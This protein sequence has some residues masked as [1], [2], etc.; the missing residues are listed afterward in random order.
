MP[1]FD[2]D[3]FER[4]IALSIAIVIVI[5]AVIASLENG[6]TNQADIAERTA[7]QLAIEAMGMRAQSEIVASYEL[8]DALRRWDTLDASGI[9]AEIAGEDILADALY[10]A[11]DEVAN[12]SAFLRDYED[13]NESAY[14]ADNFI[15]DI[16]YNSEQFT[17]LSNIGDQW[18]QK[19]QNYIAQLTIFAVTL[20][21]LGLSTTIRGF[22][23]WI[24]VVIGGGLFFVTSGWTILTYQTPVTG[25]P[26]AAIQAYAEAEARAEA[27]NKVAALDL[28]TQAIA[29]APDYANA[30]VGRGYAQDDW[31]DQIA[32]HERAIELGIDS[33]QVLNDLGFAYFSL[34]AF[35]TARELAQQRIARD[36]RL[37]LDHF[38]LGLIELVEGNRDLGVSAY[39]DGVAFIADLVAVANQQGEELPTTITDQLET[40]AIDLRYYLECA[41]FEVCDDN[42]SAEALNSNPDAV[43]AAFDVV[44][45][46][47]EVGV[48]LEYQQPIPEFTAERSLDIMRALDINTR[49]ERFEFPE[50]TTGF[51]LDYDN[52]PI[53]SGQLVIVKTFVDF[54]EDFTLRVARPYDSRRGGQVQVGF[55]DESVFNLFT[56]LYRVELYVDYQFAAEVEFY[57]TEGLFDDELPDDG[58]PEFIPMDVIIEGDTA[59]FIDE[60]YGFQLSY[61]ADWWNLE[62]IEDGYYNTVNP[63]GT[64]FI[65]A[66]VIFDESGDDPTPLAQLFA[67]IYGYELVGDPTIME[68]AGQ[69]AIQFDFRLPDVTYFVGRVLAL[70]HN[71]NA[72]YFS[73]ETEDESANLDGLFSD[74]VASIELNEGGIISE[75]VG[76][77]GNISDAISVDG[78]TATYT[79]TTYNFQFS[80]PSNWFDVEM[81]EE[82]YYVTEHPVDFTYY[83]AL[84]LPDETGDPTDLVTT[85]SDV[86]GLEVTGEVIITDIDDQP[87]VVFDFILPDYEEYI[88]RVAALYY[89]GNA[90]Y[91]SAETEEPN[92]DLDALFNEL[93]A[94][95][96]L[97]DASAEVESTS[98]SDNAEDE[99]ESS[100]DDTETETVTNSDA[101][102]DVATFTDEQ[103]GFTFAYPADWVD[104]EAIEAGYYYTEH[105]EDVTFIYA[106][107]L[108]GEGTDDPQ[109][110]VS[111]FIDAFEVA[112]VGD[113]VTTEVA[114]QAA[115]QFDF[116]IPDT[117]RVVALS[118]NGNALYFSVETEA[119]DADISSLFE[120]LVASIVLQ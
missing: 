113:P 46:L 85:F 65:Y 117:G 61:P 48:A 26:S 105:P 58:E 17:N 14:I 16:T 111:I 73:V 43:T 96:R 62:R 120:A 95:V 12:L 20:F 93:I 91:F 7:Q 72:L 115:I 89:E 54:Q 15:V 29:L 39:Q 119:T 94:S 23:R 56:G 2:G 75:P 34:G 71:D 101:S 80:Y 28:Y 51:V 36:T 97:L 108:D 9:A 99:T 45:W 87:A 100:V 27:Q 19:S 74:L 40:A 79:D 35:D 69:Q 83:Y 64:T 67:D 24:F 30:Y 102:G 109:A 8:G 59:T 25:L 116:A 68:V 84:V 22:S 103:Y 4:T 114:G 77:V 21:L 76:T 5:T 31:N 52:V 57:I 98:D 13:F 90:L 107:G 49:N 53:E 1:F 6:S 110:L 33:P 92:A 44:V 47:S 81:L 37:A 55:G 3:P 50:G 104:V 38:D 86:F 41:N 42:V 118:H 60:F 10:A 78:D 112:L 106:R 88:G 82:G 66:Q 18:G 63:D 32:D 70:Y 11:R